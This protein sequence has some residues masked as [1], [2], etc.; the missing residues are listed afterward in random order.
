MEKTKLK[1]KEA[2]NL[3]NDLEGIYIQD[4]VISKGLLHE[5]IPLKRKYWMGRLAK[6]LKSH[7]KS[8]EDL[9]TELIKKLGVKDKEGQYNIPYEVDVKGKKDKEGNTI[10]KK[11]PKFI[12]FQEEEKQAL[13]AIIEIEHAEFYYSDI[14]EIKSESDYPYFYDL[15]KGVKE[16]D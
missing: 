16:E 7:K 4:K 12:E 1:L 3:L 10:K 14:V 15:L 8:F 5:V 11:N 9:R 13:D 2:F 6:K